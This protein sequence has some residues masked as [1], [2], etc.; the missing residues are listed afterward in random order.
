MKNAASKLPVTP[1][2]APA[3]V[4]RYEDIP[5]LIARPLPQGKVCEKM[6]ERC[7]FKPD[8]TGYIQDH[9]DLPRIYR[10]VAMGMA[11]WCHETVILDSRTVMNA[12]KQEPVRSNGVCAPQPHFELCRG[13]HE[14]RMKVWAQK[15][16]G[17]LKAKAKADAKANAARTAQPVRVQIGWEAGSRARKG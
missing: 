10:S 12:A 4:D 16:R 14:H 13:G 5:A 17:F 8:G 11:F 6:C 1:A 15:V 9:P 7:P 2:A 3:T